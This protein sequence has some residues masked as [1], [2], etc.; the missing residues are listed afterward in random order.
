METPRKSRATA[1]STEIMLAD[2]VELMKNL[3]IKDDVHKTLRTNNT[4]LA[5]AQ[6]TS[7]QGQRNIYGLR[8]RENVDQQAARVRNQLAFANPRPPIRD[9]TDHGKAM[10]DQI[11]HPAPD[12]CKP[13]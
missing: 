11:L 13:S 12:P 4:I 9:P 6:P 1:E 2:V 5:S 7:A 3:K 10:R 8:P